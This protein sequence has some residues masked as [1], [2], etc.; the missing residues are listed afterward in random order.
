M[1]A[2][3][4]QTGRI[5]VHCGW[6][7]VIYLVVVGGFYI[8]LSLHLTTSLPLREVRQRNFQEE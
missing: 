1:Y 8:K 6:F 2:N 5:K 7:W 3:I 4:T